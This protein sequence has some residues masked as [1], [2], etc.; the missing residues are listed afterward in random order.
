MEVK[1]RGVA[2]W[3]LMHNNTGILE[4]HRTLHFGPAPDIQ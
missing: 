2:R 1:K 3:S 4:L